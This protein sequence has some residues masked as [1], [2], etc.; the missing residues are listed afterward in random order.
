[1]PRKNDGIEIPIKTDN[2]INL[3]VIPNCRDADNA[4]ATTPKIEQRTKET[5]AKT[6]VAPN[7]SEISSRTSLFK[8]KLRPKSP[9]NIFPSQIK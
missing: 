1:M 7:L 6:S 9:C 8:E 2:V 4:P 5:P 3:S